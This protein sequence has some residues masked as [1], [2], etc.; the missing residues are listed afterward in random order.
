MTTTSAEDQPLLSAAEFFELLGRSADRAARV[1]VDGLDSRGF[2]QALASL[3]QG[4]PVYADARPADA[5]HHERAPIADP[6]EPPADLLP[7]RETRVSFMAAALVLA[8]C[9][10]AGAATAAFVFHDRVVRI[11]ALRPASR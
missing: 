3:E 6:S 5:P 4:L 1:P 8:A 7:D 9:L 11:T 2:E 10:T